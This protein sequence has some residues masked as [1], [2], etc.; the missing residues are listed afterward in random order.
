MSQFTNT[1][2]GVVRQCLCDA[3]VS[4]G[5]GI[6]YNDVTGEN[7]RRLKVEQYWQSN[8][9][10]SGAAMSRLQKQLA[11]KFGKRFESVKVNHYGAICVYLNDYHGGP[12]KPVPKNPNQPKPPAYKRPARMEQD[13][14]DQFWR[15][16]IGPA[17]AKG[18]WKVYK[19]Q[20]DIPVFKKAYTS[21]SQ[22]IVNMIIPAGTRVHIT[23]GKC[24]AAL[25]RVV[26]IHNVRGYRTERTLAYSGHSA[27]FLYTPGTEVKPKNGF[28]SADE[29]DCAG[30][31]HFF[32]DIN[33]A[34]D[35]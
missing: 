33:R 6:I 11:L 26:S 16:A 5:A 7:R 29:G 34:L 25:A 35:W 30:G 20:H 18:Y 31:I 22:V 19:L 32:I 23:N 28:G 13:A 4:N 10:T 8:L 2:T 3:K 24:R 21:N 12:F 14:I 1:D 17:F 27:S 15:E 9:D